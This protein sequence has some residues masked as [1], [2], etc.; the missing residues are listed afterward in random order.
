MLLISIREKAN[1]IAEVC[2]RIIYSNDQYFMA[3]NFGTFFDKHGDKF[4]KTLIIELLNN[5]ISRMEGMK[6][7]QLGE[8]A[9]KFSW[10]LIVSVPNHTIWFQQKS[11]VHMT[12]HSRNTTGKFM[13]RNKLLQL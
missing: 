3:K 6:N 4:S 2:T 11:W 9:M 12:S 10:L 5:L 7:H 1:I 8:H 13:G